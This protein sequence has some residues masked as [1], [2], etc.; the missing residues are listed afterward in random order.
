[1]KVYEEVVG[2]E[3]AKMLFISSFLTLISFCVATALGVYGGMVVTGAV[4]LCSLNYWRWPLYGWRRNVDIANTVG[5]LIYQ[6]W[7]SM[8][9]P[10]IVYYLVLTYGGGLFYIAGYL[11]HRFRRNRSQDTLAGI[12]SHMLMHLLTNCGNVA[13]Y[14]GIHDRK[15]QPA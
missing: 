12:Y 11:L 13:L 4:F 8:S 10:T 14:V 7:L 6:T 15:R 1:M 2:P 9:S 3:H 5:C